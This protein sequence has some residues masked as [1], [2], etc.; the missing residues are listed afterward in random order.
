MPL[1][2]SHIH[3]GSQSSETVGPMTVQR[4]EKLNLGPNIGGQWWVGLVVMVLFRSGG[5]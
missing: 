4:V 2:A 3:I 1:S 5:V